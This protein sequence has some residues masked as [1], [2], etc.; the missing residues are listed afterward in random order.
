MTSAFTGGGLG[1]VG[2]RSVSG[3]GATG[4]DSKNH[5]IGVISG[6]VGAGADLPFVTVG[7]EIHGGVSDTATWEWWRVAGLSSAGTLILIAVGGALAAKGVAAYGWWLVALG[8]ANLA[9][10]AVA[11]TKE[12]RQVKSYAGDT[13]ALTYGQG[14]LTGMFGGKVRDATARRWVGVVDVPSKMGYTHATKPLGVLEVSQGRLRL[15]IRPA[16]IRAVFGVETLDVTVGQDVAVS[17]ARRSKRYQL[18]GMEIRL[19]GRPA[20]YFWS[21]E[22]VE[23]LAAVAAAGF[24]V[25]DQEQMMK[26]RW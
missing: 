9:V 8:L 25:S 14:Q 12:R 2:G 10:P 6:S 4:L 17:P 23:V 13:R 22:Y 21:D 7:W 11:L 20:F 26:L 5:A 19:P 15:W 24:E 16:I 3:E 1:E 18:G